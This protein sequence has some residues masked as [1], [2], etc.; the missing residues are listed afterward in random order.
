MKH[1]YAHVLALAFEPW[2]LT[3]PMLSVVATVLARHIALDETPSAALAA[4]HDAAVVAALANRK[5]LPQP[6]LGNVAII[7]VYGVMAPRATEFGDASNVTSYD[8]LAK[9]I[10]KAAEDKGVRNIV[11]DVDSPGGSVAGNQELAAEIMRTRTKK[12]IIAHANF[13]MA[14]AAYQLASAATEIVAAPSA[15]IGGIG[16]YSIHNDLSAALAQLGIKRTY[17]SA[18][19]G[20]VDGN[21]TEPLSDA[22]LGRR[23]K[24]VNTAYNAFV[25]TVVHGRGS[26]TTADKVRDGWQAH[27]YGADEAKEIGMIDRV[28][29]FD[30]TI[31]RLLDPGDSAD[32][33]ALAALNERDD[34]DAPDDTRQ[35]REGSRQDQRREWML[36]QRALER[37]VFELMTSDLGE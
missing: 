30:H 26:G 22:A 32:R 10:R 11:L 17:I 37:R 1:S 19:A 20:K 5:N 8:R 18:G 31:E 21:E 6:R 24:S 4:E 35:A 7:P 25:D 27:V 15:Q 13:L 3:P 16:T 23:Q 29:T 9:Q 28:A 14:S 12:P 34:D 33:A 36:E 2:N